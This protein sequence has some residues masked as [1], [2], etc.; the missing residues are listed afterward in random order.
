MNAPSVQE[1]RAI[2]LGDRFD[3]WARSKFV[4]AEEAAAAD[5]ALD[6]GWRTSGTLAR[7][8]FFVF[9]VIAVG[10]LFG[11]F[12]VVDLPLKGF[13][14]A[15]IACGIAELLIR[16]KKLFHGGIEEGLYVGGLCAFIAGLPG[17]GKVE[18][19]LLFA[20]AFAIAGLRTR[21]ALVVL[22][23]PLLAVAYI[24]IKGDSIVAAGF[25][26]V[27]IGVAASVLQLR[28]YR[29][30]FVDEVLVVA[31]VVMPLVGYVLVALEYDDGERFWLV[32]AA[33]GAVAAVEWVAALAARSHPHLIAALLLTAAVAYEVSTRIAWNAD[34]KLVA[35][36][37]TLLLAALAIDRRLREA[38]RMTSKKLVEAELIRAGEI[39]AAAVV[40]S[41]AT[42][43]S[44]EAATA[45]AAP[46]HTGDGGEFG[47]AGASGEY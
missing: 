35:A 29:S 34:A 12:A 18:A 24:A 15:A 4:A 7:I 33:F 23:A 32:V 6:T 46:T 38:T 21:T 42:S 27:A 14:T 41:A 31:T 25:T 30:P 43:A 17:E 39:V 22:C 37:A 28:T 10:C 11:L 44:S 45:E 20:A 19:I 8:A 13:V 1:Q 3:S 36:G 2:I 47:G 9:G 40:S 16:R 5:R 26:C